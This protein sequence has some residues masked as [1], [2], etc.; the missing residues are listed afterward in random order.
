MRWLTVYSLLCLCRA[1][2][3]PAQTP[4]AWEQAARTIRRLPPDS[5]PQLPPAIRVALEARGCSVPQSFTSERPHNVITGRFA[6]AGQQD[7]AILCSR[8]DS[9]SV[10]IFWGS[11]EA[12]PPTEFPRVR[13]AG[14]L[15]GIGEGRIGF[16][17]LL[18]VATPARIR[19]YAA[20]F[21]GPLPAALDHDGVEDAFAEKA[22]A[23]SYFEAGRWL[24]LAGA[25]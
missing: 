22:S 13:D 20:S 15:Q 14:F 24:A 1:H 16:S 21:D 7:W 5:F 3:L 2:G 8:Q 17:R 23:V 6:H 19:D 11:A 10:L 12:E 18:M 9:S 4:E 25:D